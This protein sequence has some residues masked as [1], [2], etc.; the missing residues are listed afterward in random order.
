MKTK[1]YLKLIN[2]ANFEDLERKIK[3]SL[4]NCIFLYKA[5]P[6][7]QFLRK[8]KRFNKYLIKIWNIQHEIKGV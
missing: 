1:N 7:K 6:N 5:R 4:D 8:I 2:L 3:N